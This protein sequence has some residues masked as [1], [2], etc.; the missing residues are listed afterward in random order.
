MSM[1]LGVPGAANEAELGQCLAGFSA[2]GY[3]PDVCPWFKTP[4][5]P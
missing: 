3:D 5:K 1:G 4:P 2:A